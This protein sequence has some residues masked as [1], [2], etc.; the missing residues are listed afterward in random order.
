[1]KVLALQQSDIGLQSSIRIALARVAASTGSDR[2]IE[3]VDVALDVLHALDVLML[4]LMLS[5]RL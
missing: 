5:G 4:P 2:T 3:G 1:M